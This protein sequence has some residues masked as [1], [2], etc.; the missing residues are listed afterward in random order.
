MTDY[1]FTSTQIKDPARLKFEE[2]GSRV[3]GEVNK[4]MCAN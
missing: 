4:S 1:L 3:E 2:D